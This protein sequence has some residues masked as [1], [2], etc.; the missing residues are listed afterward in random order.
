MPGT[1]RRSLADAGEGVE[2]LG[3]GGVQVEGD[4]GLPGA[5][6]LARCTWGGTG[7]RPS[8]GRWR[9]D[10]FAVAG[11]P[12]LLAVHDLAGEVDRLQVGTRGRAAG[13]LDR[14]EDPAAL[15][16]ADEPGALDSPDHVDGDGDAGRLPG[17]GELSGGRGGATARTGVGTRQDQASPARARSPRG[18]RVG[19]TR[20]RVQPQGPGG[21]KRQ[22]G[23]E[24]DGDALARDAVEQALDT[25]APAGGFHDE[26][27][28][29]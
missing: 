20:L 5:A 11:D 15:G 25:G 12:D 27:R 22:D 1:W 2:L 28:R 3:G 17:A 23:D 10:R 9:D 8:T 21:G 13:S 24:R 14:V 7:T 26:W 6:G 29:R 4:P 19:G 16:K 18:W